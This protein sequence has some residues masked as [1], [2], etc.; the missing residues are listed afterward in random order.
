LVLI[1][2]A[3]VHSP[4]VHRFATVAAFTA[5]C[6]LQLVLPPALGLLRMPPHLVA[7]AAVAV[8]FRLFCLPSL[9][10]WISAASA[11]AVGSF[12]L[13]WIHPAMLRSFACRLA[14][15]ARFACLPFLL[16]PAA[17]AFASAG[18]R[19]AVLHLPA[20]AVTLC[21]CRFLLRRG[22]R[23]WTY[24]C[25]SHIRRHTSFCLLLLLPPAWMP[26]D[27]LVALPADSASAAWTYHLLWF[28]AGCLVYVPAP[29]TV[30]CTCLVGLCRSAIY[31]FTVSRCR[32]PYRFVLFRSPFHFLLPA[33]CRLPFCV[34]LTRCRLR[35]AHWDFLRCV[36]WCAYRFAL[37]F[38][39]LV[40]LPPAR[41]C[42]P[43]GPPPAVPGTDFALD[44]QVITAYN[45]CFW[46]F[47]TS[48]SLPGLLRSATVTVRYRFLV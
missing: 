15:N 37:R 7:C 8:P 44:F 26:A 1:S 27:Y 39:C 20:A 12:C 4:A 22:T 47:V 19:S 30:T 35:C 38:R 24:P 10:G 43:A 5:F 3:A 41:C 16:T 32:L 34:L 18:L 36:A 42:L 14:A 45:T 48:V 17:A 29:A 23:S 33:V 28:A 11:A 21:A 9:P 40:L 46:S 13:P 31:L 2:T 25:R 6:R